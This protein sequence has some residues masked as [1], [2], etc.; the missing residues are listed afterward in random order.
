[1]SIVIFGV[2]NFWGLSKKIKYIMLYIKHMQYSICLHADDKGRRC[3]EEQHM[4]NLRA[5]KKNHARQDALH[6]KIIKNMLSLGESLEYYS[7][8][9]RSGDAKA[10]IRSYSKTGPGNFLDLFLPYYHIGK[11]TKKA[12]NKRNSKRIECF[13]KVL[14]DWLK[15]S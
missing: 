1:M 9:W 2:R 14:G 12:L 6:A 7:A 15:I 3:K 8:Y 13:E 10:F 4:S 11:K 5:I